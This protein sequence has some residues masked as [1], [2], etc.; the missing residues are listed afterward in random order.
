MFEGLQFRISRPALRWTALG[1][2]LVAGPYFAT[3]AHAAVPTT[4]PLVYRGYVTNNGVPLNGSYQVDFKLF[5]DADG[6]TAQL[7]QTLATSLQVTAG[8]FALPLA[9][10]CVD[11][12]R[13]QAVSWAE[14]AVGSQVLGRQR[15]TA[16]PFAM[17]AALAATANAASASGALRAEIDAIKAAQAR[18]AVVLQYHATA[19][20]VVSNGAGTVINFDTL[21]FDGPPTTVI[22]KSTDWKF[23]APLTGTYEVSVV[24]AVAVSS[25]TF[26]SGLGAYVELQT[27]SRTVVPAELQVFTGQTSGTFQGA[28]LLR[29]TAGQ[30]LQVVLKSYLGPN[31]SIVGDGRQNHVSIHLVD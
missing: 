5:A 30:A 2:S 16:V 1:I 6:G 9:S 7:C 8:Q 24:L 21:I 3:R 23:V 25:G 20:Q 27:G 14:V 10:A 13:T 17:E 12:L 19:G 18:R 31:V 11:Q 26:A 4:E 22:T 15:L 29:L 28:I